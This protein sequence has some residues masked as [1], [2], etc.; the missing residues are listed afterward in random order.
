MQAG[1][2]L[3]ADD[4]GRQARRL[5]DNIAGG[6]SQVSRDD[7]VERSVAHFAAADPEYGARVAEAVSALRGALAA[8]PTAK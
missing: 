5:V 4:R 6:L 1:R 3:P 8:A 2:P 7:I